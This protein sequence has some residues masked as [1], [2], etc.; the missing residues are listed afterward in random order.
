MEGMTT[1][2]SQANQPNVST[3]KVLSRIRAALSLGLLDVER[4]QGLNES[5]SGD[6]EELQRIAMSIVND[7]NLI[8][9][10]AKS[11]DPND[12]SLIIP[13]D[14]VSSLASQAKTGDA[15]IS[16][17][18]DSRKLAATEAISV[19]VAQG[20]PLGKIADSLER[21]FDLR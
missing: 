1:T 13:R 11:L 6:L 10:R 4:F 3:E 7:L 9:E 18:L 19:G 16:E 15:I 8:E 21:E 14:I 12:P 5:N 20:E 17:W 2:A